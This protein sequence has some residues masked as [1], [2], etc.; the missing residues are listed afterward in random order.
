MT[1]LLDD[2]LRVRASTHLAAFERR[3]LLVDGKR[4]A[5]VAVVLLGDEA[6]RACFLLTRRASGLRQHARQWALPGGRLEPGES[7]VEGALR[8]LAEEV[9][10][11]LDAD[12]ALGVLDDYPTR[13]G[14]LLTPVVFWGGADP[15]LAPT[16]DEVASVHRV[17]LDDLDRPDVPRL[18]TI[19][20]S[21][22]PVIQV[23]LLSTLVHA[24][25]AAVLYQLREVVMHGR[26][27]R[28]DHFEQP[29]WAWG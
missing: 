8:E 10:L 4:P 25:T 17:P 23:P 3:A 29:V 28:V 14:F 21:D 15:R 22:R 24:P 27:T 20:E 16:P 7:A 18:V 2:A 26:P 11:V 19:P 9:G 13:S 5:A 6:G 12:A 1:S